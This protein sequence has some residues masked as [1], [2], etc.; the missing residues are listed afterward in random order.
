MSQPE[1]LSRNGD[2]LIVMIASIS[3][4]LLGA[5]RDLELC[6]GDDIVVTR[7]PLDEPLGDRFQTVSQLHPSVET[8]RKGMANSPQPAAGPAIAC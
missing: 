6:Q 4:I 8:A 1:T 7:A 5:G 2:D 3:G